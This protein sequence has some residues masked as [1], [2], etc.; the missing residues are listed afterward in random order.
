MRFPILFD[1][2]KSKLKFLNSLSEN[3][4]KISDWFGGVLTCSKK[5]YKNYCYKVG[6]CPVAEKIA[7][8]VLG[9]PCNK[10]FRD[11]AFLKKLTKVLKTI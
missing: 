3:K 4:I 8:R 11:K 6:N 5:D 1:S 10:R 2:K 7:Y 9:I